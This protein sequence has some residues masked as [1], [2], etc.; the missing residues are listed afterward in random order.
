MVT[1]INKELLILTLVMASLHVHFCC[2]SA[3]SLTINTL[4][5]L[6][7]VPPMTERV[8]FPVKQHKTI[9][10]IQVELCVEWK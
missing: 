2:L 4:L 6:M 3:E 8:K 9:L 1:I 5:I 7:P 10:E